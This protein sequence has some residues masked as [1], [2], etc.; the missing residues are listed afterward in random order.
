MKR[1]NYLNGRYLA[2][3]LKI[4]FKE[5]DKN[6]YIKT[7]LRLS[8][9]GRYL[10]PRFYQSIMKMGTTLSNRMKNLSYGFV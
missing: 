4:H 5:Q 7:E 8:I 6:P 10:T 2:E 1:E 3:L 9:Y